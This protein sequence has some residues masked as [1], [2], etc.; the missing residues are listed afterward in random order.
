MTVAKAYYIVGSKGQLIP[1]SLLTSSPEELDW[2]T[3]EGQSKSW[4][5]ISLLPISPT[6]ITLTV[7]YSR[8]IIEHL[9]YRVTCGRLVFVQVSSISDAQ[10]I[11]HKV[12]PADTE[13]NLIIFNSVLMIGAGNDW[14]ILC[15][16]IY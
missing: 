1:L 16:G 4:N 15:M 8:D 11:M 3:L 5:H 12:N 14:I 7:C 9:P 2:N 13:N 10:M 6:S